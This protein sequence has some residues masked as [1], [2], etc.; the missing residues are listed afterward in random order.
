MA[1]GAA[2]CCTP[3]TST[4]SSST[5]QIGETVN[6]KR[7][8]NAVIVSGPISEPG[9]KF[10]GRYQVRY[11]DGSLYHAQPSALRRFEQVMHAGSVV[12][13]GCVELAAAIT[14]G[15]RLVLT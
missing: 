7:H 11:A 14:L 12:S 1:D 9:H 8:G 6:V 15:G 13:S 2:D 5:F 4:S 3:S 10:E